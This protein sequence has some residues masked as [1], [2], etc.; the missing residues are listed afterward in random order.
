MLKDAVHSYSGGLDNTLK[1]YD[2]NSTAETVLGSHS[3]A[4]RCVEYCSEVNGIITGSWDSTIKLWDP[5]SPHCSGTYNCG[6]KVLIK[7]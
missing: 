2:F 4:V 5:R 6:D 3:N 7:F 1:M